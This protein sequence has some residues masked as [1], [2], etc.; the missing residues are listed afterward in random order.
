[1]INKIVERITLTK[2]D[3]HGMINDAMKEKTTPDTNIEEQVSPL[4]TKIPAEKQPEFVEFVDS[5]PENL[6]I[7][8]FKFVQSLSESEIKLYASKF[9]TLKTVEDLN[10]VSYKPYQKL[11]DTYVGQ[12]IGKGELFISYMVDGAVVQGSSMSYDIDDRG[13]HYEVKSL[14]TLKVDGSVDY[15]NIRPGAEGKVSRFLFTKQLMNYYTLVKE[16]K[17]PET[18]AAIMSLGS[19]EDMEN[20]YN[21]IDKISVL[22]PKGGDVLDSPGDIPVSM[23]SNVYQSLL[24]LHKIKAL[25]LNKNITTSRIAI[26]GSSIDS[27]YWIS[28]E[29]ANDIAAAAGKDTQVHIKVG[30]AVT[31][32][33]K[34][35][36]I[37]LSDFLNHPFVTSPNSFIDGL[38]EIK[39]R[40]F[41]EKAGLVYFYKGTTYVSKNMDEFATIESS[42][43]SYRFGL[44]SRYSAYKHVEAQR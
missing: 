41:G 19:K 3:I 10:D 31:D 37:I 33:T 2:E 35:G 39:N 27:Q 22:K 29:D 14:D 42:Q 6:R 36:K 1:M 4:Y 18:R 13:K 26:K 21:I 20:L 32:E 9:K 11:W 25:P 16:L 5:M 24:L 38:T 44:K 7:Q 43:D 15:G 40:F 8:F 34:E 23:M 17:Q 28:P 12:A 30:N